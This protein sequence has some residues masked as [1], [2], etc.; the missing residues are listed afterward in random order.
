M[1]TIPPSKKTKTISIQDAEYTLNLEQ[2]VSVHWDHPRQSAE[3]M[4]SAGKGYTCEDDDYH[5]LID[6][7]RSQG[8]EIKT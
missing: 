1:K 3:A 5:K 2:V 7:L 8:W 4:T 6:G